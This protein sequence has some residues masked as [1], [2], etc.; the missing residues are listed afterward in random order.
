ML[1]FCP[2]FREFISDRKE[3]K[4]IKILE[5]SKESFNNLSFMCILLLGYCFSVIITN[6]NNTKNKN[7]SLIS[8]QS[9]NSF[10]NRGR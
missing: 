10:Q 7:N 5:I 6:W 1:C 4:T 8:S 2:L 3:D 9:Q